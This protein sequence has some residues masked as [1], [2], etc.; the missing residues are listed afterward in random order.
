VVTAEADREIGMTLRQSKCVDVNPSS[1]RFQ[2]AAQKNERHL[3]AGN[4]LVSRAKDG[5]RLPKRTPQAAVSSEERVL[6]A[7]LEK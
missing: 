5:D 6:V 7:I 1:D 4:P 2:G 3:E